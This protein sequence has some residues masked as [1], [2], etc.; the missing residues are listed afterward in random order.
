M[1]F[2]LAFIMSLAGN[3]SNVSS[4]IN[5]QTESVSVSQMNSSSSTDRVNLKKAI[6]IIKEPPDQRKQSNNIGIS[7]I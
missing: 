2:A 5:G 3:A 1:V 4:V 6:S 7:K